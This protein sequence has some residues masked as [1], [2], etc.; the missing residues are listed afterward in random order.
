MQMQWNN[1]RTKQQDNKTTNFPTIFDILTQDKTVERE[2]QVSKTISDVNLVTFRDEIQL[3]VWA[4]L[5]VTDQ[6][7]KESKKGRMAD[8]LAHGGDEGRDK[9]R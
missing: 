5:I 2:T 7:S 3:K 9:L 1:K 6:L 8:A 4:E